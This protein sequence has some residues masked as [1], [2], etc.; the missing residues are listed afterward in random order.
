MREKESTLPKKINLLAENEDVNNVF[1]G[2]VED[3][4][5]I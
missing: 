5:K 4:S 3:E 1:K 2:N